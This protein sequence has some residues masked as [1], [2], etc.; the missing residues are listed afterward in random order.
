MGLILGNATLICVSIA[1][2]SL[3]GAQRLRLL[4]LDSRVAFRARLIFGSPLRLPLF[5]LCLGW[6][7]FRLASF[8]FPPPRFATESLKAVLLVVATMLLSALLEEPRGS[9]ALRLLRPVVMA[10]TAVATVIVAAGWWSLLPSL[11]ATFAIFPAAARGF[12]LGGEEPWTWEM[13]GLVVYA[14]AAALL[15]WAGERHES[16]LEPKAASRSDSLLLSRFAAPLPVRLRKEM[17]AL[18]RTRR[19]RRE[20]A[21]T[22]TIA[23]LAFAVRVPW[24]LLVIPV[25]WLGFLSNALGVDLPLDGVSRYHLSGYSE[26]RAL[27]WRHAA[28]LALVSVCIALAALTIW[29][30]RGIAVPVVGMPS[31][32][33]YAGMSAYVAAILMLTASATGMVARRYPLPLSRRTPIFSPQPTGPAILIVW[34]LLVVGGVI[35]AAA[36]AFIAG[37]LIARLAGQVF[38]SADNTAAA[39]S[40]AAVLLASAFGVLTLRA[41][42]HHD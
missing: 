26:A 5:G 6:A 38:A 15:F 13:L 36:I 1:G 27:A 21:G 37:N 17:F 12:L 14:L 22:A 42:R 3:S 11:T 35:C 40:F 2:L 31:R 4:P 9:F 16:T 28:I 23:L 20:I 33:Q 39:L 18:L 34:L 7:L 24:L 30:A 10:A 29:A 25:V 19:V 32:W 8:H 41:V